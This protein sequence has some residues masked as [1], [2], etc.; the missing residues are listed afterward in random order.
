M[1]I[2]KERIRCPKCQHK[3][4]IKINSE[5]DK[6]HLAQIMDRSLFKVKCDCGEE[7]TLDYPVLFKG[8]NYRVFYTHDENIPENLQGGG[9]LRLVRDYADFKEKIMILEDGLND[10]VI[11][12]IKEFLI[13]QLSPDVAVDGL[14]YDGKSATHLCFYAKNLKQD[15]GCEQTFYET[16]ERRMRFRPIRGFV[17]IDKDSYRKYMK[18]K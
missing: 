11:E 2:I 7:I 17:L 18:L 6:R 13:R 8:D 10:I 12:F 9:I 16:I 14:R 3:L 15:V 4:S 5:L 1:A